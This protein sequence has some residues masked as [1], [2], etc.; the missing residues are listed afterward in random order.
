[1]N[2]LANQ[3]VP[4]F[5]LAFAL[6]AGGVLAL[7]QRYLLFPRVKVFV[8]FGSGAHIDKEV[9]IPVTDRYFLYV[10]F[11]RA[12]HAFK[13]LCSLIGDNLQNLPGVPTSIS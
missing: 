10:T 3:A 7:W 5:V 2:S 6:I 1:M 11:D 12:G 8:D 4:L 13:D 9:R